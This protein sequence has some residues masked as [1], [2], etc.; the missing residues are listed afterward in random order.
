[1]YC[2]LSSLEQIACQ[3]RMKH[4]IGVIVLKRRCVKYD[5]NSAYH[6]YRT[7]SLFYIGLVLIVGLRTNHFAPDIG[8][9]MERWDRYQRDRGYV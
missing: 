3:F 9:L 4:I 7:Y 2:G 6:I 1:M 8:E 5:A